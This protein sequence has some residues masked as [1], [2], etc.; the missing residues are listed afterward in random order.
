MK[1]SGLL[2]ST[3]QSLVKRTRQREQESRDNDKIKG[4][5]TNLTG[6]STAPY[7]VTVAAKQN[8]NKPD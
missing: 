4:D 2:D 6:Q 1:M 8:R 7:S 5:P 3:Q